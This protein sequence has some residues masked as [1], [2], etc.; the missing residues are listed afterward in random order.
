VI[1]PRAD[2]KAKPEPGAL[3]IVT[4][5]WRGRIRVCEFEAA[6]AHLDLHISRDEAASTWCIEARSGRA[7]NAPTFA[8]S[9]STRAAALSAVGRTW[10]SR[11]AAL[12]LGVFD[13]DAVATA[14]R[15]VGALD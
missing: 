11:A 10:V 2:R 7:A 5:Y 14:L 12:G 3:K 13:W 15:S 4:Q 9:G 8:E 1:E 6:G